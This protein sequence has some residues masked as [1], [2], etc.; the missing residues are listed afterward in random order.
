M[1]VAYHQYS[2]IFDLS[3]C[4]Y[5]NHYREVKFVIESL[6]KEVAGHGDKCQI[7]SIERLNDLK[8]DIDSFVE[9]E[10]LNQFQNYIVNNIYKLEPPDVDFI[11]RSIIII[12]VP[13]P[14]YAK[15]EFIWKGNKHLLKSLALS[16]IDSEDAK[17]VTMQYLKKHLE[18]KNY[19]M[20][21]AS[22]LPFKRLAVSSGLAVYGRN[23][24]CY[25]DGMGSFL[26][27]V[28]YFTDAACT[29][30]Q[31]KEIKCA[32]ICFN[33]KACIEN[34]PTDAIRNDR[35]LIDNERCL[36]YFNEGPGEFPEWIP[37]TAHHCLY[38]C[39]KCQINCTMN[40]RYL[41][42]VIG[43]VKFNEEETCLLLEGKEFQEFN[44]D[45]QKKIKILGMDQWLK[46]IPRNLK[47]LFELNK[48]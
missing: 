48:K 4:L 11:P 39:L 47:I 8:R 29:K 27:L 5:F 28:A 42:N 16:N 9:D 30:D 14:A 37:L 24:I 20:E 46:A 6:K 40:K 45:L 31:W 3:T 1:A 44:P 23:N 18:P 2:G 36:S 25:V 22:N 10:K 7:V 13:R 21:Y 35:F 41:G 15:V 38:D 33:C 34:C 19:H 26:T 32:D 43:P 17:T 12:A